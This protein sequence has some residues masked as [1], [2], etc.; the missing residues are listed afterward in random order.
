[1][2]IS[3]SDFKI[4]YNISKTFNNQNNYNELINSILNNTTENREL[5]NVINNNSKEDI[6]NTINKIS[7]FSFNNKYCS[8]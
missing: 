5:I 6:I 2:N 3:K 4:I 8:R 1:M 7:K